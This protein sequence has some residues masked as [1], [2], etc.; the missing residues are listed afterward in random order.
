V[1]AILALVVPAAAAM[2]VGIGLI[3][4][5][6]LGTNFLPLYALVPSSS[7]HTALIEV[8]GGS[9]PLCS[10]GQPEPLNETDSGLVG[11]SLLPV[12]VTAEWFPGENSKACHSVLTHGGQAA[13]TALAAAVDAEPKVLP[14]V[15]MCPADD[16]TSVSL[17]FSYAGTQA[18]E[19]VEVRLD[20]CRWIGD[21]GRTSR[22][23]SGPSG[24][25]ASFGPALA[26]LAPPMWRGYVLGS[27]RPVKAR[28]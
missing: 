18:A 28:P 19:V 11:V 24:V 12:S 14:G 22:W 2:A 23:W 8:N 9:G 26:A 21:S 16:G 17:Y 3:V 1:K 10:V 6:G 4:A 15:Y 13:A 7:A 25:D 20:G 27:P 5:F